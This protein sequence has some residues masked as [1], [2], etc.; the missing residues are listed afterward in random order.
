MK[1]NVLQSDGPAAGCPHH[2]AER[3]P[4]GAA[5]RAPPRV[6][7]LPLVGVLP[8]LI[9]DPPGTLERISREHFGEI[10]AVPFGPVRVYLVTHPDHVQHVL[11][12]NWRN[13][14][15]GATIYRALRRLVGDFGLTTS[16]GEQWRRHREIL[17]PLFTSKHLAAMS[18]LIGPAIEPNLRELDRAAEEREEIDV[19]RWLSTVTNDVIMKTIFGCDIS[20]RD[21]GALIEAV[22]TAM[23]EIAVRLW[24]FMLPE[25]FPLPG[26]ARL[27]RSLLTVNQIMARLFARWRRE[28]LEGRK[29][30]VSL[31]MAASRAGGLDALS[32]REIHD[33]LVTMHVAG[34]ET[35]AVSM[36]WLFYL[37]DQHPDVEERIRAE[38]GSVV[39]E[40]PPTYA[41]LPR[42]A[43]G[44][45]AIQEALR[46]YPPA[47]I[48]PRVSVG[49]DV[50]GSYRIPAGATVILGS[51]AVQHNP[52]LWESPE[53]F[54]PERFS[55]ERS[56]GR[57]RFAYLPFGGGP[58]VCIGQSLS[59][60]ESQIILTRV[61]Q[62]FK[63][64][65]RA[66]H[67]VRGYVAT[68]LKPRGGLPMRVERR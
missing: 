68:T 43:F 22:E 62:R 35:T 15:K 12:D 65:L 1:A 27:R 46:L 34:V 60:A 11:Q 38:I 42:L 55:P 7:G 17:Q 51:H 36:T 49:D 30:L 58:R 66:N 29:D 21:S 40:R 50:I 31:L 28:D 2:V 52:T 8:Q 20:D 33:E 5:L 24:L 10:V 53:R 26:E 19:A 59:I 4:S 6:R 25:R 9:A 64:R 14:V 56:A 37:L 63:L 44:R 61:L 23:Q 32:E 67:R 47:V 45:W 41:D 48:V 13:Y 57:H 54:D 39:G 3:R 16:D 18:D